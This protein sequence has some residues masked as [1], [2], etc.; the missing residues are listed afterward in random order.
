MYASTRVPYSYIIVFTNS[1]CMHALAATLK[2]V[3]EPR[4]MRTADRINK[5]I[6]CCIGIC[7]EVY[8]LIPIA[9]YS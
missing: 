9:S 1:H 6:G 5:V 2:L 7:F 4:T 8:M 3:R